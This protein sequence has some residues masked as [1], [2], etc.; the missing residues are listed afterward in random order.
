MPVEFLPGKRRVWERLKY[1]M[2]HHGVFKR[3][4]PFWGSQ[5]FYRHDPA[6]SPLHICLD[7]LFRIVIAPGEV[8]RGYSR[9]RVESWRRSYMISPGQA[10][11]RSRNLSYRGPSSPL[12]HRALP[13]ADRLKSIGGIYWSWP[14]VAASNPGRCLSNDTTAESLFKKVVFSCHYY[15]RSC[16]G[17]DSLLAL[18]REEY[19]RLGYRHYSS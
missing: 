2:R 4:H 9:T 13:I 14:N 6:T 15:C 17:S 12:R 3:S 10:G 7:P 5:R 16:A 1:K 19:G 11:R 8:C 18:E